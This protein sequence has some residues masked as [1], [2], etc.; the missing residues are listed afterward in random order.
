VLVGG[1]PRV[2]GE[3]GDLAQSPQRLALAV[4]QRRA[5]RSAI[6]QDHPEPAP[7]GR[8]R[9]A[10]ERRLAQQVA[11]LLRHL[12]RVVVAD[13]D[14]AVLLERLARDRR[15]LHGQVRVLEDL[16]LDPVGA[17]GVHAPAG[18]V[19]AEDDRAV[20]RG[21]P[22]GRLA[23]AAVEVVGL[24]VDVRSRQKL[25]ERLERV[26]RD[27]GLGMTHPQ[28]D[29]NPRSRAAPDH[30]HRPGNRGRRGCW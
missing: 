25:D 19:V 28:T 1:Q 7:G 14:D 16:E 27:G 29:P 21:D 13:L 23:E 5:A 17:G 2:R 18:V 20:H 3:R 4:A 8:H 11:V 30:P 10:D 15:R 12:R 26:D 24:A 9:R 6:G 22:A